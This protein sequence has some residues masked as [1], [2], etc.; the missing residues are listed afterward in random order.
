MVEATVPTE[1]QISNETIN[2]F[3]LKKITQLKIK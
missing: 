3:F 2:K 1:L